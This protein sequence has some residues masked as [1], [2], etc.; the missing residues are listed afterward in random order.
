MK[1]FTLT[2]IAIFLTT[3]TVFAQDD[4]ARKN[5]SEETITTEKTID[6]GQTKKRIITKQ[7]KEETQVITIHKTD[8]ENQNEVYS[9]E[10]KEKTTETKTKAENE[11]NKDAKRAL[12]IKQEEEI[13]ASKE[14]EK[15]KYKSER[16]ELERKSAEEIKR[17][18]DSIKAKY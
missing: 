7:V 6:D 15:A 3:I 13:K 2:I 12:K 8:V 17:K 10:K 4:K 14:A 18:R 5:I 16:L 11:G 9:T 1:K